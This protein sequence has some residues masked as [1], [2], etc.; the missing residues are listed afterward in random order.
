[1]KLHS[2]IL[3]LATVFIVGLVVSACSPP[4]Q[5]V[6]P[7][8]ATPPGKGMTR[9]EAV[10]RARPELA[11]RLGVDQVALL[12]ESVSPQVWSNTCLSL[13]KPGEACVDQV[14]P[15][16]VVSLR[17]QG[18]PYHYHITDDAVRFNNL[19]SAEL[20]EAPPAAPEQLAKEELANALG[21][22][23]GAIQVV[24]IERRFWPNTGL[25]LARRG[26]AYQEGLT[27]GAVVEL[28]YQGNTY[29]Y[30][31]AGEIVRFNENQ[32]APLP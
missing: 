7:T 20:P 8:T 11:S 30:H 17:Y 23:A 29:I 19:I 22:N 31:V 5:A 14:T 6:A 2:H 3:W 26:E 4:P 21:V 1:M 13:P 27:M 28:S 16:Y 9:E 15:G 32:S 18:Q 12:V 10:A 25:G 24:S